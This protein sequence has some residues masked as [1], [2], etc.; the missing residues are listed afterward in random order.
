VGL[1]GT[2]KGVLGELVA[3]VV[4]SRAENLLQA[5]AGSTEQL[6]VIDYGPRRKRRG[7]R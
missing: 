4:C 7:G 3:V 1:N 2:K 5:R 6:S